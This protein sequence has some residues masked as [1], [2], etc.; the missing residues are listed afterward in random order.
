[1]TGKQP[2]RRAH[3]V[4]RRGRWSAT[5][6]PTGLAH[7]AVTSVCGPQFTVERDFRT[8]RFRI[9]AVH[10]DDVIAQLEADKVPV[11]VTGRPPVADDEFDQA[12]A[13]LR[14]QLDAE[15]IT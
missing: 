3:V 2:R 15:E 6:A 14:D 12:V 4:V 8:P 13:L 9:G 7:R 10:V 5:V 1:M 11:T